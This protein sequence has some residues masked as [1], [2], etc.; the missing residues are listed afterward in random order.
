LLLY[1]EQ[2]TRVREA[3]RGAGL[4]EVRLG[5]DFGGTSVVVHS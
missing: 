1:T 4:R 5:F 2:K 3:M